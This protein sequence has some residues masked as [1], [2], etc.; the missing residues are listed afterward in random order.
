[1]QVFQVTVA[2]ISLIEPFVN[3]KDANKCFAILASKSDY[4]GAV[5]KCAKWTCG[6]SNSLVRN[7][8]AIKTWT[9]VISAS[10]FKVG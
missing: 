9:N 8:A 1:M 6:W 10:A 4:S 3:H 2:T 5:I 7:K